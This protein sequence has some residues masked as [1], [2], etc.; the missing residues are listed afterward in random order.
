M[1]KQKIHP[2]LVAEF[3]TKG[4]CDDKDTHNLLEEAGYRD[5]SHM[6]PGDSRGHMSIVAENG[7]IFNVVITE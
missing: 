3:L 2:K 4:F 1:L 7:Q 5:N 6:Y